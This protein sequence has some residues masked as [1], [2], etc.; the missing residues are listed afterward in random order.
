M[1]K[2]VMLWWKQEMKGGG[3]LL[4]VLPPEIRELKDSGGKF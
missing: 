3:V 2:C 4:L 1:C